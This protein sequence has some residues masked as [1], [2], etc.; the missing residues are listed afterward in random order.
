MKSF[1]A[2]HLVIVRHGESEGDVRRALLRSGEAIPLDKHPRNEEQ[3]KRGYEQSAIA[4]K[5]IIEHILKEYGLDGFDRYETSPLIRTYQSADSLGLNAKWHLNSKLIE[6]NRGKIHGFT[7]KEHQENYPQSFEHMKKSTFSWIPPGGETISQVAQRAAKFIDETKEAPATIAM[8]HR[9]WMWAVYMPLDGV[10]P[11]EMD[12]INTD[13][14]ENGHIFHYTNVE[15]N[16]GLV[17]NEELCWKRAVTPWADGRTLE[18]STE[19]WIRI[20]YDESSRDLA[21]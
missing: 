11:D 16:S 18:A 2:R 9:D 17:L 10:A 20:G 7:K 4:G 12:D 1:E 15:P 3:T 14:I 13:V 19:H 21:A 6:R 5:W 8:T